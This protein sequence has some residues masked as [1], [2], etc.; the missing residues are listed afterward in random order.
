MKIEAGKRYV[1]RD[2]RTTGPLRVD[3]DPIAGQI[4]IAELDGME[5][6]WSPDGSWGPSSLQLGLDLVKPARK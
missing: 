4:W 2:G 6:N 1:T 3:P 5:R